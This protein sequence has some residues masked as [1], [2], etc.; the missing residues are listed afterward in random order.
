MILM[1]LKWLNRYRNRNGSKD[2]KSPSELRLPE[3][4]AIIM[5]G[6]GRW[7]Q[8]RG[9]PRQAG[10]RA[11]M[12]NLRDIIESCS[13]FGIKV[14]TLFAFSTENWDRPAD[15]VNALINLLDKSLANEIREMHKNNIKVIFT[16]RLLGFPK[17]LQKKLEEGMKLTSANSSMLVNVALNYGA[18]I[19]MVDAVRSIAEKVEKKELRPSQINEE[20]IEAHLYTAGLPDPDLLIRTGGEMRVSNFLLW[21]IAYTELWI[22]PK[23]W[24]SFQREDLLEAI[25]AYSKRQ[26]RFGR[27]ST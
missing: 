1:I 8:A 19:E 5:D 27:V 26:R 2:R 13:E 20:I 4:V 23:Y 7:A 22:T 9:L 25:H 3:H 12:E 6:N 21:Q 16:G 15:E 24:P 18:R 17:S 11:G 14:L 10:H